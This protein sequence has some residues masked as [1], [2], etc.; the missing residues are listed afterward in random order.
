MRPEDSFQVFREHRMLRNIL[1]ITV[2]L[3]ITFVGE[4]TSQAYVDLQSGSFVGWCMH[5]SSSAIFNADDYA[6][7]IAAMRAEIAKSK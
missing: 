4:A 1:P 3:M 5:L 7:T 6:S 2:S